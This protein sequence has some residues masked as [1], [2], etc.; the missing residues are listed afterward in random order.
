MKQGERDGK[1]DYKN[2]SQ[3]NLIKIVKYLAKDV[4]RPVTPQ[5]II[6]ALG[7]SKSKAT[8]TLH[9]LKLG[10]WAEQVST[11]W[12]LSPELV[13]IA[14]SVRSTLKDVMQKYLE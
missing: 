6:D 11:G 8:W 10:G 12:R 2:E 9:N 3:Q 7:L 1:T 13:K 14:D 4:F 5:E